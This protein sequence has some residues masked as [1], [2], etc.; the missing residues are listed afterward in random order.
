MK[1]VD[2]AGGEW[3]FEGGQQWEGER[4]LALHPI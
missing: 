4:E 2:R 3:H 1:Q